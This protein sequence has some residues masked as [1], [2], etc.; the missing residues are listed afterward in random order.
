MS[1]VPDRDL[2]VVGCGPAGCAAAVF[3]ARD[4][5]DVAVFD[6]GRSSLA[7]CAHLEN[8]P[9][10]PAGID[11]GTLSELMRAQA[12]RAGC[13]VVEDLVESV[14]RADGA[15][16][17][18][19]DP[20]EPR[21]VVTPQSGDPVDA[22]RVVAATRYDG[23]Y[24]RGLD[25]DEAMFE[26]HDHGGET[27]EHFDREYADRDGTTPVD[28]LYV[29][30][31]SEADRQA[32]TAAGRGARVGKKVVADARVDDGWWPAAAEGVDWVRREAEL[33]GEWADRGR[34]VEWFDAEHADGPVDPN[35][36]RF[37]RVREAAVDDAL[38]AYVDADEETARAAAG[39]R[40]LAERLD[41]DA[42]VDA[43]GAD[44]LLDAMDDEAVAA[45][46]G[47]E[48]LDAPQADG[49]TR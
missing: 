30:S 49:G 18:A 9:G 41:P 43:H 7:R 16:G 26:V 3:A 27:H 8:Y 32:V 4:G 11:V 20:D 15:P 34:W 40:A 35:S 44:V 24:L 38:S 39:H 23:E 10:F 14:E 33:D 13:A 46:A 5:L 36:A 17:D 28:G 37:A 22:R 25:G 47:E 29:A 31:P 45:Y 42:V 6:R 19:G 1:G 21:F 12:E 48:G 2:V